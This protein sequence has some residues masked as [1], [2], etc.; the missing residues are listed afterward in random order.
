MGD[1]NNTDARQRN[2]AEMVSGSKWFDG[3]WRTMLL[4]FDKGYNA[5]VLGWVR[6][7]LRV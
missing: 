1:L 3:K 5:W 7:K 2:Q 4:C 6:D